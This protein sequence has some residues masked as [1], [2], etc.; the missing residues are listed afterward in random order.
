LISLSKVII[1]DDENP[2]SNGDNDDIAEPGETIEILPA[3]NNFSE[4]TIYKLF[5]QFISYSP[6][7]SIWDSLQGVSSIVYDRYPYN[8]IN[9]NHVPVG[10][11]T[12]NI[13]PE[14]D[15]VFDHMGT[16][17]S[18][19][20]F[21]LIFDGYVGNEPGPLWSEEG[22]LHKWSLSFVM[23][24]GQGFQ[25]EAVSVSIDSLLDGQEIKPDTVYTIAV[26][27]NT[28]VLGQFRVIRILVNGV[29][30]Y[31]QDHAPFTFEWNTASLDG[32]NYVIRVEATDINNNTGTSEILVT[33]PGGTG[34]SGGTTDIVPGKIIDKT[35]IYPN[36]NTGRF[37]IEFPRDDIKRTIR[38]MDM[39]GKEILRRISGSTQ[40]TLDLIKQGKGLYIIQVLGDETITTEKII[41]R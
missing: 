12:Q 26:N 25:D 18:N 21:H 3:I 10:H 38:I 35:M 36:P 11:N 40:E 19:L 5:G 6:A 4:S 8:I 33:I 27:A 30:V 29:E 37:Y 23:N 28:A 41:V 2:D 39:N 32:G 17:T 24:D 20:Y 13:I 7:I 14:W 31:Q 22:V 34:G 15:Y 1:D 9:Q 16:E